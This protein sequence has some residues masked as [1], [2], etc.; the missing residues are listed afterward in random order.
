MEDAVILFTTHGQVA[1]TNSA[2]AKLWDHDAGHILETG[3]IGALIADWQDI[4]VPAKGWS[5]IRDFVVSG[6][7]PNP[8]SGEVRMN[9]GR[10]VGF[11]CVLLQ[12]GACLVIFRVLTLSLP[13]EVVPLRAVLKTA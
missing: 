6:G 11:R 1:R 4:S 10:S 5:K 13:F 2:Y 7:A 3:G 12:D 8:A 9:D